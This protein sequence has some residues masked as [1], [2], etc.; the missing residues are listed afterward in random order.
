MALPAQLELVLN[1]GDPDDPTVLRTLAARKLGLRESDLPQLVLRRRSLDS[2]RGRPRFHLLFELREQAQS[3][4]L[5]APEPREVTQPVRVVIVGAGPAG[6]FCAYQLA[7]AGIGCVVLDRG[8]QVQPRRRDLRGLTRLGTVNPDSNYCFGEGGAGT[9]SDGKLYTRA[10][11]RGDVRD[12][13]EVLVRH[14]APA[15]I[16]IDA[17]PHIG[18]NR[19]P[20]VVTAM[21]EHLEQ[22][23]V[24]LRFEARVTRLLCEGPAGAQ[25]VAGVELAEGTQIAAE[26]VVFATGHSARDVLQLLLDAGEQ[27]EPKPFALGVR[28][29][30]PQP[31]IDSIQYGRFAGHAQLPAASYRLASTLGD[32]RVFSFCMCPGGFVVPAMTEPGSIVVNGM[33]LSKRNSPYANSGFV[34]GVEPAAWQAAG[35]A[36]PLGGVDLQNAIERAAYA[37]GDAMLRAPATRLGDFMAGRGSSSVPKSSYIPGLVAADIAE[38]LA[39]AKLDLAGQLRVALREVGKKM[40]RYLAEDAVLIGVES[41]TSS[42]VRVPRDVQTLSS[43]RIAGLYPCGEGAGYAGGIVSAALDGINVAKRIASVR[44]AA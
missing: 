26:Q 44:G 40:P 28:I 7:R 9:Y 29:E 18:S 20:K 23:G 13:L 6:L 42:P 25:R 21:R 1:L 31:L 36:G 30:H 14:G 10:E 11:K 3:E 8:K 35:F 12:V 24:Q 37:T 41:R 22:V 39:P 34:V 38:V 4:P 33:S 43:T 27:L 15:E 17:R 2:R 16:L 19:L 32:S 5:A